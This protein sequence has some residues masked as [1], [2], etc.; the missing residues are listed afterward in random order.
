MIINIHTVLH[1][2][3]IYVNTLNPRIVANPPMSEQGMIE[4]HEVVEEI[5]ALKPFD[6]VIASRLAR[7]N[8]TA[9]AIC[10][11]LD[12]DWKTEKLLGQHASLQNGKSVLYPGY[13]RE[14][15]PE[16]LQNV[17]TFLNNLGLTFQYLWDNIKDEG[18]KTSS[19]SNKVLLFTHR[20][21]VAAMIMLAQKQMGTVDP[22]EIKKIA[23][24]KE[25]SEHRLYHFT[26]EPVSNAFRRVV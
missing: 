7:A 22:E 24:G 3:K 17:R 1:G 9:S 14:Y 12:L 8:D 11:P 13:E 6:F 4:V 15:Y 10:I 18:E 19:P 25:I 2:D 21:I 23:R 26:Y 5:H 20:P 16:W